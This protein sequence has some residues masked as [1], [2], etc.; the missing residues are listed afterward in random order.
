MF[1]R[2]GTGEPATTP[3]YTTIYN[4]LTTMSISGRHSRLRGTV[5]LLCHDVAFRPHEITGGLSDKAKLEE[6]LRLATEAGYQFDT[7]DN[8]LLHQVQEQEEEI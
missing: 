4:R 1:Q 8:P 2:L 6:F 7:L 3:H 5:I